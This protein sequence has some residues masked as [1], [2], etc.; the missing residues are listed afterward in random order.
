MK[1]ERRLFWRSF[2]LTSVILACLILGGFGI[3]EAY[4]NTVRIGLGEYRSAVELTSEGLRILD[5]TIP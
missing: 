1:N 2:A 5:F 4:E 3:K